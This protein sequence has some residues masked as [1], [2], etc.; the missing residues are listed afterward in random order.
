MNIMTMRMSILITWLS[1]RPRSSQ[2]LELDT[3]GILDVVSDARYTY[4]EDELA[5]VS[6]SG[7]TRNHDGMTYI[8]KTRHASKDYRNEV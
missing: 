8:S 3:Q 7:Y 2:Y 5:V 1:E 4:S 6:S